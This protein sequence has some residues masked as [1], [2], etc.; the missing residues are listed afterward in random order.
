MKE[1]KDSLNNE[2]VYNEP[3]IKKSVSQT[4]QSFQNKPPFSKTSN[5]F[6]QIIQ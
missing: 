1:I 4:D 5:T 6:F 3:G 2:K